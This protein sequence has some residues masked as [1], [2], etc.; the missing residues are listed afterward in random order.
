MFSFRHLSIPKKIVAISMIISGAA[1][2]MSSAA[3][4][5]YELIV[6]E[7]DPQHPNLW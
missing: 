3:L 2:L 4:V 5:T 1:L 7:Q 6:A